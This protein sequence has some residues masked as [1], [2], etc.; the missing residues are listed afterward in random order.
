[1]ELEILFES[2]LNCLAEYKR[3]HPLSEYAYYLS[4]C[5]WG[6][7]H[8]ICTLLDWDEQKFEKRL[9]MHKKLYR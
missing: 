1:M 6:L 4:G 8:A 9:E 7:K 5:I 2:Y 3:E